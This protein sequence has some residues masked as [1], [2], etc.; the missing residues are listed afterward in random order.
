MTDTTHLLKVWDPSFAFGGPIKQ[1]KLW[2]FTAHRYWGVDRLL[3]NTYYDKDPNDYVYIRDL[4]RQ[5]DNPEWNYNDDLRLTYAINDKNRVSAYY[6]YQNK[7][8]RHWFNGPL[9]GP[10]AGWHYRIPLNYHGTA[11]WAATVSPR[12]LFEAGFSTFGEDWTSISPPD[13]PVGENGYSVLDAITGERARTKSQ[14]SRN[15]TVLRVYKAASTYVT[16]SHKVKFG[17]V[18]NEG[19]ERVT[20]WDVR[21]RKPQHHHDVH[22]ARRGRVPGV[23][24]DAAVDH[25]VQHALDSAMTPSTTIWA[26][27]RRISGRST[28]SRSMRVSGSTG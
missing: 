15:A 23:H 17:L 6:V 14:Q 11:T 4:A 26:C 1:D 8:Q 22:A 24:A 5:G 3:A 21:G 10:E 20:T 2:F 12:L 18:V 16:G 9:T 25:G 27:T 28:A 7:E 19:F 13:S